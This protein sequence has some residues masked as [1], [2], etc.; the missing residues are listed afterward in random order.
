M[1]SSDIVTVICSECSGEFFIPRWQYKIDIEEE[2]KK[3]EFTY[4]DRS[5]TWR[6]DDGATDA[7]LQAGYYTA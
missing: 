3:W 7:A 2:G 1:S 6:Q 5:H 4:P